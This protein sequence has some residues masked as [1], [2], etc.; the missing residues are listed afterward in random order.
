[1]SADAAAIRGIIVAPVTGGIT[2]ATGVTTTGTVIVTATHGSLPAP[3][4]PARLLEVP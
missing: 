1:V 3:L 2:I 4:S